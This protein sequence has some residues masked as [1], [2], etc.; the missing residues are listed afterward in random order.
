M[1][2]TICCRFH[3][4][5]CALLIIPGRKPVPWRQGWLKQKENE[6]VVW[7]QLEVFTAH[8]L[9]EGSYTAESRASL[10]CWDSLSCW[11]LGK[12]QA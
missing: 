3:M 2:E 8:W 11:Q 7:P 6:Q 10:S 5:T 1:Q 12:T 4:C 9:S